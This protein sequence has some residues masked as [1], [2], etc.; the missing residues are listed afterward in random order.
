MTASDMHEALKQRQVKGCTA[1]ACEITRTSEEIKVRRI[2]KFSAYHNFRYEEDG[3]WVSRAYDIGPGK[4][5]PW[6][7]ITIDKQGPTQ[8]KH[9]DECD[10]FPTAP[11]IIKR[12]QADSEADDA[13]FHC[14]E[15]G[16]NCEFSS[17]EAL[18]D[19][20]HF[21]E[22]DK[23]KASTESVY[24]RLRRKWVSKFSSLTI[25]PKTGV[26]AEATASLPANSSLPM[27]WALQKLRGGASRFSENVKSYLTA[28]F[29]VGE[30]TGRKADPSQVAAE[31]RKARSDDGTR[32][33]E[34]EEWLTKKQIQG[35]FLETISG[36]KKRTDFW[37]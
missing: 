7:K 23:S 20:I 1:S 13:L 14:E 15:P 21:G 22:H 36:Q 26:S 37:S 16:C 3:L 34:R 4:H 29:D 27:G 5:I 12:N 9:T 2:E 10:F 35:F 24:D 18:Q 17:F 6:S 31:M 33:F 32:R 28:R 11:R 8:L 30:S 25:H 19:H